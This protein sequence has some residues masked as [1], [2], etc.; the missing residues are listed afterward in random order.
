MASEPNPNARNPF[1]V[2]A[3]GMLTKY[4]Q[5]ILGKVYRVLNING[6]TSAIDAIALESD[7]NTSIITGRLALIRKDLDALKADAEHSTLQSRIAQ[8][9]K[10]LDALEADIKTDTL[11]ARIARA[12]KR[13]SAIEVQI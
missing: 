8:L 12:E 10:R 4:G 7:I 3:T 11:A 2:P 5:D 13:I 9:G 1:V 6:E